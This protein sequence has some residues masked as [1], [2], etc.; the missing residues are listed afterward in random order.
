MK[1]TIGIALLLTVVMII[2]LAA[3]A[4]SSTPPAS[5]PPSQ[6]PAAQEAETPKA[7]DKVTFRLNYTAQGA[8]APVFYG[9]AKGIFEKHGID[10]TIGEGKGSG[11]TVNLIA[12]GNDMFG[13]ADFG[14][15]C[16]L[17]TQEAPVKAIA[18]VYTKF[19]SGVISIAENNIT[20]PEDIIGKKIGITEGDGPHRT[21]P[22][23]LSNVGITED[24]LELI[25]MDTSAKVPGLL[26]GQVDAILGGI[27]DQPF[28]IA[29]QGKTATTINYADH[30]VNAIGLSLIAHN[31]TIA[32]NPELCKRFVLA[33]A[34]CWEQT[35]NDTEGALEALL[36]QFPDLARDTAKAQ[37]DSGLGLLES[38][39]SLGICI[40]DDTFFDDSINLFKTY[41]GLEAGD[42]YSLFYTPD[43]MPAK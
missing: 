4:G 29:S 7:L 34:E 18:P 8:H 37:L 33:Y 3:C 11:N 40:A 39:R 22:A 26:A 20:K 12:A 35:R 24:Q 10:I 19:S 36:A 42:D 16:T 14:T 28:M 43:F 41:T 23:F 30:G 9:A 13:F 31:D 1:K 17:V 5:P 21:F 2:G 25:A 6:A 32:Q 27:D 38:E 15:M